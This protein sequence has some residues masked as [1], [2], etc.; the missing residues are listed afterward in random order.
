MDEFNALKG[1]RSRWIIVFSNV[2]PL[3]TALGFSITALGFI[4]DSVSLQFG[5]FVGM[6]INVI[7]ALYFDKIFYKYISCAKC[8]GKLNYFKNGNK[9]PSERAW[10]DLRYNKPCRH[11]GYQPSSTV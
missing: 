11:C 5:I 8:D 1:L 2:G 10:S 6:G 3:C 4:L 9:K 7:H